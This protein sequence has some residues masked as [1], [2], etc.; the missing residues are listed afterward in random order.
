MPQQYFSLILPC[1]NEGPTFL[2]SINSILKEI[3]KLHKS[4]GII[5]V[6]DKSVDH[7]REYIE[8]LVAREF[9][10]K[11]IYHTKNMGRG[12]SV[13]DGIRAAKGK[14]VGFMD[15]DCEISPS[16]IPLFINEVENGADMV[17]GRRF[18]ESS[19]KAISRVIASKSYAIISKFLLGLPFEDTEAGFKFFKRERILPV[20]KKTTNPGWFWDTEICA[21]ANEAGLKI[22][23]IPVLFIRRIDKK[24]TVSLFSDSLTYAKEL[25]KFRFGN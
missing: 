6:E 1:Y 2:K 14:I 13:S 17:I 20:L 8:N 7:T 22:K 18:Y 9:R 19:A 11:A 24:S 10:C 5:L 12:A 4:Y 15:V 23:Q 3:K 21:R 25:L 16:Y